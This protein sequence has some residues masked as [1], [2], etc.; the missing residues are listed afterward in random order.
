MHE[1]TVN[2]TM[3][4]VIR[5]FLLGHF[6]Y[7]GQEKYSILIMTR[8]KTAYRV[9]KIIRQKGTPYLVKFFRI[10]TQYFPVNEVYPP[11]K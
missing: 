7:S 4:K 2:S 6:N 5:T 3:W 11:G 8:H 1:S 9:I 10:Q